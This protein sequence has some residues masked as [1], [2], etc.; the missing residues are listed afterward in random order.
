PGATSPPDSGR[1]TAPAVIARR[2][3]A[4]ATAVTAWIS[5]SLISEAPCWLVPRSA[6]DDSPG[7][8]AARSLVPDCSLFASPA[9][10][11][12]SSTGAEVSPVGGWLIA[13]PEAIA[14]YLVF[15]ALR[16]SSQREMTYP[17]GHCVWCRSE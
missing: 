13:F 9:L 15:V 4:A 2:A 8:T 10:P 16:I 11:F 5:S 6:I 12:P 7:S 3:T 1:V 14:L 17:P